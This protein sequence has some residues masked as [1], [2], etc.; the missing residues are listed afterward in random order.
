MPLQRLSN[1][2]SNDYSWVEIE[3]RM[4]EI[5]LKSG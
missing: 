2:N 3:V 4:A 5:S 1:S